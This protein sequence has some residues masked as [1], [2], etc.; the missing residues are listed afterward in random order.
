MSR[1]EFRGSLIPTRQRSTCA[2]RWCSRARSLTRSRALARATAPLRVGTRK[3][4]HDCGRRAGGTAGNGGPGRR[5][6]SGSV[7]IPAIDESAWRAMRGKCE[8]LSRSGPRRRRLQPTRAAVSYH[9]FQSRRPSCRCT[10]PFGL[11]RIRCPQL[12]QDDPVLTS[13]SPAP[14][15]AGVPLAGHPASA[16]YSPSDDSPATR[17]TRS[18]SR[19]N[20]KYWSHTYPSPSASNSSGTR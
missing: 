8:P 18:S 14:P 15:A 9:W 12:S 4:G 7:Q 1:R 20:G 17:Q 16:R 2:V 6:S 3:G 10:R 13:S 11:V 19:W 5:D